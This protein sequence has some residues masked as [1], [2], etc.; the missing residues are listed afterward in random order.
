LN[1]PD[2]QKF[3]FSAIA[4]LAVTMRRFVSAE[5]STILKKKKVKVK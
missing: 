1:T 4:N 3:D 5:E 2:K